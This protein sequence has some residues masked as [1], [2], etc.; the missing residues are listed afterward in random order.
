MLQCILGNPLF[1]ALTPCT[2]TTLLYSLSCLSVLYMEAECRCCLC[3]QPTCLLGKHE[4]RVLVLFSPLLSL[5][6]SFLPLVFFF[7]Q[8]SPGGEVPCLHA[9][10]FHHASCRARLLMPVLKSWSVFCFI[11]DQLLNT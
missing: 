4:H 8:T 5:S 11:T 2:E 1:P 9:P 6:S 7:F 3:A 10:L